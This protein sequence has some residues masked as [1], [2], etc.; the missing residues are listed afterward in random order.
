MNP[1]HNPA[2]APLKRNQRPTNG[3]MRYDGFHGPAAVEGSVRTQNSSELLPLPLR[4]GEGAWPAPVPPPHLVLLMLKIG[5]DVGG[6]STD[7]ARTG[8]RGKCEYTVWLRPARGSVPPTLLNERLLA[9]GLLASRWRRVVRVRRVTMLMSRPIAA[10]ASR[11]RS[12]AGRRSIAR[13]CSTASPTA[14]GT[15]CN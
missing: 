13:G 10:R 7:L 2:S 9:A 11:M 3:F 6:T 8:R 12:S 4:E 5:I 15:G 14:P 1:C